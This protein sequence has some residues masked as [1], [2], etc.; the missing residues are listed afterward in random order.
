MEGQKLS[1]AAL[2]QA[3]NKM[4]ETVI[5]ILNLSGARYV[6]DDKEFSF[7]TGGKRYEIRDTNKNNESFYQ[8]HVTDGKTTYS[9]SFHG[10]GHLR[11]TVGG[12]ENMDFSTL[13]GKDPDEAQGEIVDAK[14]KMFQTD[15]ETWLREKK[16]K[17]K[18]SKPLICKPNPDEI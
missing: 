18:L 5:N 16:L 3:G 2:L 9:L 14:L 17:R 8:L 6:G 11:L 15:C 7:E 12:D 1:I 4:E 13:N 10:A